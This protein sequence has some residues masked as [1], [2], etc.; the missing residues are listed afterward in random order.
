MW[1]LLEASLCADYPEPKSLSVVL[2]GPG[3][4]Q[5]SLVM[6]YLWQWKRERDPC[7]DLALKKGR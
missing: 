5:V 7:R 2:S 3:S 6:E 4:G 1:E